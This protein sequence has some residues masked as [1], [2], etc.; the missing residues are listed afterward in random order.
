MKFLKVFFVFQFVA[1]VAYTLHV[2]FNSGWDLP[3]VFFGDLF[4]LNWSGQFNFDFLNYLILSGIWVAWRHKFSLSGI[5]LG[6]VA[7]I[8]G[9]MFFAPYLLYLFVKSKDNIKEILL[10]NQLL[11]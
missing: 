4:S 8:F 6:V 7:S 1:I 5:I 2:G 3:S 10:G 9:I 11:D